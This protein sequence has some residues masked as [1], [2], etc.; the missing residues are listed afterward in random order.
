MT[1]YDSFPIVADHWYEVAV[2]WDSDKTGTMPGEIWVDDQGTDGAGAGE[3]W[4]GYA[5]CTDA[6]QSQLPPEKIL[7]EG[8]E[9][10]GATGSIHIGTAASYNPEVMFNGEI[11]WIFVSIESP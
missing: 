2:A 3:N 5:N 11:D 4:A 9:I 6:D 7:Y 10:L 8:D 1:D